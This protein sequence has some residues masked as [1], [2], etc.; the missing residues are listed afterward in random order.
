MNKELR[1]NKIKLVVELESNSIQLKADEKLIGQV[2]I[3]LLRNSIRA[4]SEVKSNLIILKG[5]RTTD[6]S[7]IIEVIDQGPGIPEDEVDKIFIPFYT[8]EKDGSGIGLSISR[9]I[10]KIHGGS[11]TVLSEPFV[12]TIFTLRF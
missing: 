8:T 3:N 11:I 6:H 9:Q 10:M 12:R 4:L 7:N 5:Y 1:S 2:L